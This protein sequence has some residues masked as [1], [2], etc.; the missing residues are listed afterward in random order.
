VETPDGPGEFVI[1]AH[2]D[3]AP[4][5]VARF[6]ELVEDQFYDDTRFFRVIPS[7]MVQFG[8]SGTPAKN[9]EW[10]AK[11]IQDDPVKESNKPGYV[12]F[13]KTGAP[14][15][16]TTQVRSRCP[17]QQIGTVGRG[18]PI[19]PS[20]AL[21]PLLTPSHL[22]HSCSST[23]WTTRD[24]TAWASRHSERCGAPSPD[25]KAQDHSTHPP[26]HHT[27][28]DSPSI[29]PTPSLALL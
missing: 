26:T 22:P 29:R 4:N 1:R 28:C 17:Q 7:F 8:L 19:A 24:S 10:R 15:S 25:S 16:R 3:W 14:N 18:V 2:E 13:A 5:G 21:H 20:A 23:T 12:T 11:T 9:A 27:G 6:R